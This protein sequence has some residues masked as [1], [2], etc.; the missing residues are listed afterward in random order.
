LKASKLFTSEQGASPKMIGWIASALEGKPLPLNL[1]YSLMKDFYSL[2]DAKEEEVEERNQFLVA[3]LMKYPFQLSPLHTIIHLMKDNPPFSIHHSIS[4]E[5]LDWL[6]NEMKDLL[7]L[8][9]TRLMTIP[10]SQRQ[11][12]PYKL[13]KES[14]RYVRFVFSCIFSFDVVIISR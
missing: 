12:N 6:E 3:R 10:H 4:F 5:A 13:L 8:S 11:Y 7:I 14:Y 1:Q 9:S 2:G